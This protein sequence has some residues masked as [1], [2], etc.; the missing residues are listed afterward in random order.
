LPNT[1][2]SKRIPQTG[3]ARRLEKEERNPGNRLLAETFSG[4][5]KRKNIPA[6]GGRRRG[7]QSA[8]RG[9][10]RPFRSPGAVPGAFEGEE[11]RGRAGERSVRGVGRPQKM[12]LLNTKESQPYSTKK[13]KASRSPIETATSWGRRLTGCRERRISASI[14]E[15]KKCEGVFFTARAT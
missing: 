14:W 1:L 15:E 6:F 7:T 2:W 8:E 4:L 13:R 11:K 9:R 3:P 5:I 12:I 10:R